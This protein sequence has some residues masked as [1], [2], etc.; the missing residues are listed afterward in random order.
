ML[1]ELNYLPVDDIEY[2]KLDFNQKAKEIGDLVNSHPS[3][4]PYSI[5]LN[6]P[7]GSGKSSML[8][9]VEQSLEKDNCSII[10]FNPWMVTDS[11]SL[12]N[13]LFEEIYFEI[14]GSFAKAKSKF[15]EYAQKIL[16]PATKVATYFTASSNGMEH[17]PAIAVSNSAG[18]AVKGIGDILFDRPLSKRKKDLHK[19]MYETYH[20]TSKKIVILIDEL[21]RLFPDE[22]ITVFQ[23]IKSTLD[24]PGLIFIVAMDDNVVKDAIKQKGINDPTYYLEKIF[25]RSFHVLTKFQIRTM[26]DHF[27]LPYLTDDESD[28]KLRDC[29][30]AYVYLNKEKQFTNENSEYLASLEPEWIYRMNNDKEI[31]NSYIKIY[32]ELS[33]HLNLNNPRTFIKF[34]VQIKEQW[35]NY[36]YGVISGKTNEIHDLHAAFLILISYLYFPTTFD[37]GKFSLDSADEERPTFFKAIAEHLNLIIPRYDRKDTTDTRIIHRKRRDEIVDIATSYLYLHPDQKRY[38]KI[39]KE[40]DKKEESQTK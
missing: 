38:E 30:E 17:G 24:F 13:H 33:T 5:S 34:S 15:A 10:R 21:D 18:E 25:Q 35:T 20:G 16:T 12:I 39:K 6:G 19:I 36:Y 7:W 9:F 8:N 26:T 3:H 11:E 22:I 28:R 37:A 23:M 1:E 40:Q 32:K 27:L 2:D 29:L 4:L 31:N 14:D